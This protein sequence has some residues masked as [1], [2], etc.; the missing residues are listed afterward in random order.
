MNEH[1]KATL[2][3]DAR[4]FA[5]ALRGAKG[6]AADFQTGIAKIGQ[7]ITAS[8]FAGFLKKSIDFAASIK[9]I[10]D[11]TGIATGT[12][13][14]FRQK[15]EEAAGSAA[16]ADKALEKFTITIGEA[17]DG[18]ATA[19]KSFEDL[20]ISLEE[21]QASS[22]EKIFARVSDQL[23]KIKG[24]TER[25]RLAM[26]I[27]GKSGIKLAT[28]FEGGSKALREL[29]DELKKTGKILDDEAIAKLDDYDARIKRFQNSINTGGSKA[30]AFIGSVTEKI[31]TFLGTLSS[32]LSVADLFMPGKGVNADNLIN[33]YKSIGQIEKDN[34]RI[35][36]EKLAAE[37]ELTAQVE[38]T[39]RAK[40]QQLEEENKIMALMEERAKITGE[41]GK[42]SVEELAGMDPKKVTNQNLQVDIA[43]AKLIE[44]YEKGAKAWMEIDPKQAELFRDR[45]DAVKSKMEFLKPDRLM[46]IDKQIQE[47]QAK[48]VNE[49]MA[50]NPQQRVDAG[51]GIFN[52][53]MQ[54]MLADSMANAMKLTLTDA[55]YAAIPERLEKALKEYLN[56]DR[57]TWEYIKEVGIKVRN[58]E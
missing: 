50:Q 4:P 17:K 44:R 1:L 52:A 36:A 53:Q 47:F 27:F 29:Q 57:A 51:S 2:G 3:L 42:F 45:I 30:V 38:A 7:L 15:A 16:I 26:E 5:T 54:Q 9:D 6:A 49:F 34:L 33:A 20:G 41:R 11:T 28:S 22:P 55:K 46:E 31:G 39:A 14:A 21:L 25:A 23:A 24:P 13:Q 56:E 32:N 8:F 48:R 43:R 37:K 10:S 40:R 12:I 58:S 19:V 18:T 35:A